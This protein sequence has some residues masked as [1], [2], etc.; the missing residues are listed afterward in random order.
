M[1]SQQEQFLI[2]H[3]ELLL[4][5]SCTTFTSMC[6]QEHFQPCLCTANTDWDTDIAKVKVNKDKMCEQ[7]QELTNNLNSLS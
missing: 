2:Y 6:S 4:T 1:Q 3:K 7:K 5:I